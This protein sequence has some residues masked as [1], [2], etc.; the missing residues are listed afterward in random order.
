[1]HLSNQMTVLAREFLG[2]EVRVAK[3]TAS[4][5]GDDTDNDTNDNNGYDGGLNNSNDTRSSSTD[6]DGP[7]VLDAPNLPPTRLR[8]IHKTTMTEMG[9]TLANEPWQLIHYPLKGGVRS[10]TAAPMSIYKVR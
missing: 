8:W 3:G 4:S 2:E 7:T 10:K 6:D 1:M 5:C 9:N